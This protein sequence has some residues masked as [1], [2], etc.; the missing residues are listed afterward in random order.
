MVPEL[1]EAEP[2]LQRR[3]QQLVT[4]HLSESQRIAAGLHPPPGPGD[5]FAAVQAAWRFY[6]NPRISLPQLAQPLVACARRG[7]GAACEAWALVVHD[8]SNL[9]FNQH[10]GKKD[11]VELSNKNDLG[12]DLL[13]ALVVSDRDGSP[14]APVNLELKAADGIHSTRAS[15]VLGPLSQLD[16]LTEVVGHV[17]AMDLG[18]RLVHVLDR[19]ADSVALYRQ[20][21]A[22]GW[23]LLIRADDNRIVLHNGQEA[24]LGQV[25]ATLHRQGK[26]TR[27]GGVKLHGQDVWPW[28]GEAPVVLHRPAMQHRVQDGKARH[29]LIPGVPLTLRLVVSELRDENGEVLARCCC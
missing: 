14:L 4:A 26:M 28:I 19:E 29:V 13:T 10:A 21:D 15:A 3:Y 12:Y 22:S 18:R 17:E 1:T 16:W 2:R 27:T 7:V 20:W 6:S 23:H 5:S 9:R 24:Q 8:W 25:A 11:R